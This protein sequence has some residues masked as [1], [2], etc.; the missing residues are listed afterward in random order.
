MR[1]RIKRSTG[2]ELAWSASA[3]HVSAKTEEEAKGWKRDGRNYEIVAWGRK[4][5]VS[6]EVYDAFQKL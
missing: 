3:P 2:A 5:K 1:P 6:K 4:M